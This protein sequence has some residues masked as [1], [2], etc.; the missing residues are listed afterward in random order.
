MPVPQARAVE[1]R[2]ADQLLE[3]ESVEIVTVC[4]IKRGKKT[5]LGESAARTV[6]M[7]TAASVASAALGSGAG[8][9]VV[10]VPPATWVVVTNARVLMFAR[11]GIKNTPRSIGACVFSAPLAA[12]RAEHHAGFMNTLVLSDAEDGGSLVTLRFGV[13]R[14]VPARITSACNAG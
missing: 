8:F 1:A 10:A 4:A 13:R 14:K 9:L 6:A 7:S 5:Q 3:G 11:R 2:L 12:L